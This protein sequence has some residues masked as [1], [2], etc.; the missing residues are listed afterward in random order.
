MLERPAGGRAAREER[1]KR[2]VSRRYAIHLQLERK[3]LAWIQAEIVLPD[4]HDILSDKE[5]DRREHHGDGDLRDDDARPD[6]A[7]SDAATSRC[8]FLEPV[9]QVARDS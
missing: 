3:E 4:L 7:E 5:R 6:A 2:S 1:R 8:D 9:A